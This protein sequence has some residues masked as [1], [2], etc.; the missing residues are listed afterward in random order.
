[1]LLLKEIQKQTVREEFVHITKEMIV[2]EGVDGVSARKIA[3][4]ANCSYATIYNYF[5][6]MNDL[7]WHVVASSMQDM[8]REFQGMESQKNYDIEDLKTLCRRYFEYFCSTPH[9]FTFFFFRDIGLP[10]PELAGSVSPPFVVP[11]AMRILEQSLQG[12]S[13]EEIASYCG[14]I[15][16]ALH[17]KMLFVFSNKEDLP[18]QE[19]ANTI[20]TM[21]DL[22]LRPV[23]GGA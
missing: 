15:T 3:D 1:M 13:Q 18:R 22:I 5:R 12:A 2:Q 14:L 4:I 8:Q 20:D 6:D 11:L 10:P 7:L 17:G 21:V 19:I 23:T 9:L 16:E